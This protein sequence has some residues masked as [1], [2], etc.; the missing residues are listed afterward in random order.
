MVTK[1]R[2]RKAKVPTTELGI[3][4]Q[5]RLDTMNLTRTNLAKLLQ[6]STST[7][8]RMLNGYTKVIQ[9]VRPEA[10]CEALELDKMNRRAFLQI[11]SRAGFAL[12]TQAKGPTIVR[13]KINLDLADDYARDL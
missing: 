11:A 2:G 7:I 1:H 13:H 3:F 4:I 10:I 9:Q 5:K 8:V 6:V 12:V